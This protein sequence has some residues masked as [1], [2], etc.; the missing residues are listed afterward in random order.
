M[1]RL[2]VDGYLEAVKSISTVDCY[3]YA[4]LSG[5]LQVAVNLGWT[6]ERT[7]EHLDEKTALILEHKTL[8]V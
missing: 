1:S 7:Q 8:Y 6:I 4:A 2:K 3:E 5:V